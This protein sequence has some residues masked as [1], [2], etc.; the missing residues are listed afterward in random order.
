[1]LHWKTK[2]EMGEGF[3][4]NQEEHNKNQYNTLTNPY[5]F[6]QSTMRTKYLIRD[7]WDL[8]QLYGLK[9]MLDEEIMNRQADSDNLDLENRLALEDEG[10]ITNAN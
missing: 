5:P 1:M 8:E 3:A 4:F 2:E 9:E 6:E 10:S 7:V